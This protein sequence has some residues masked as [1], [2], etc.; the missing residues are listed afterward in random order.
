MAAAITET[1][2]SSRDRA[3]IEAQIRAENDAQ[4]ASFLDRHPRFSRHSA[5][6][7]TPLDASDGFFAAYLIC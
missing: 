3:R 7:L 2:E 5:R 4:I 1:A 6:T